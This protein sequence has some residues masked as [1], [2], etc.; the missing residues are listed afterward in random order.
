VT[1]QKIGREGPG[2]QGVDRY[3]RVDKARNLKSWRNPEG[4]RIPFKIV[5]GTKIILK[6]SFEFDDE[7]SSSHV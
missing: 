4:Q 3:I 7:D 5:R 1:L 6:G 2:E